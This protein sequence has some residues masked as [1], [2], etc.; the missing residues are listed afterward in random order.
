M[1]VRDRIYAMISMERGRQQAL[2]RAGKF[3]HTCA[4]PELSDHQCLTILVEEIGEVAR[5]LCEGRSPITE[6]T[7]SAAVIV[8]WLERLHGSQTPAN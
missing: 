5:D 8:A 6:L 3:K 4:D 1:T 2:Q 7:E